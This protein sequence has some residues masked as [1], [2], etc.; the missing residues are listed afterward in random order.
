MLTLPH[1]NPG[2]LLRPPT[3]SLPSSPVCLLSCDDVEICD[4][5]PARTVFHGT[6]GDS[7]VASDIDKGILGGPFPPQI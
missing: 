2:N 7:E 3:T 1:K 4:A 6:K 5:P